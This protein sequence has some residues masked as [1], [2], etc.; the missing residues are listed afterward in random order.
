MNEYDF[1]LIFKLD[2]RELSDNCLD[3]LFDAGCD[4]AT[5]SIGMKGYLGLNFCRNSNDIKTAISTAINDVL[6]VLP[7]AQL[8]RAEPD[9]LNLSEL[10]FFFNFTKQ[11]MRKYAR[12][13]ITSVTNQFPKPA[14]A[15]KTSYWHVAE[16]AQWFNEQSVREINSSKIDTL[17]A[18]WSLNQANDILHQPNP[19]MT[20]SFTS[21][22]KSVA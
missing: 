1:D 19:E 14:I 18:L 9:L 10:A 17:F 4:D 20:E 2:D 22:L 5:I 11:N 16:I 13:E 15:G 6:K 3:S 7:H 8:E 21:L 12:G